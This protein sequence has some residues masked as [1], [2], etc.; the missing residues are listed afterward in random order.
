[1]TSSLNIKL[2]NGFKNTH[3]FDISKNER[4]QSCID[5]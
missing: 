2:Q 4:E 3:I 5:N 1:M